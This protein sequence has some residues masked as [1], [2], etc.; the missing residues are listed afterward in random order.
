MK[1]K[2]LKEIPGLEKDKTVS[3]WKMNYGFKSDLQGHTTNITVAKAE[4]TKVDFAKLR[5]MT[6]VYGIYETVDLGISKPADLEL[7]LNDTEMKQRL[8]AVRTLNT[9]AADFLY[10]EI[11]KLNTEIEEEVLKKSDSPLTE[12]SSEIQE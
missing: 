2:E 10:V 11:N 7:G 1:T 6:L 3:I 4:E 9:D 12:K 5:I 8:R